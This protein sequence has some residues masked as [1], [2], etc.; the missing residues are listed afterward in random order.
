MHPVSLEESL[1]S[2]RQVIETLGCRGQGKAENNEECVVVNFEK[3]EKGIL[4]IC[5][6][7]NT[8]SFKHFVFIHTA[9][10]SFVK[11]IEKKVW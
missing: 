3:L 10:G 8:F 11:G 9:I 7:L 5:V 4:K 2:I 6:L 1:R